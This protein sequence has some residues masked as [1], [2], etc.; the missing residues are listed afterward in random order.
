MV[1]SIAERPVLSQLAVLGLVELIQMWDKF[2][3]T[4]AI[5]MKNENIENEIISE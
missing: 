5:G 4:I 3:N 1:S 2:Y